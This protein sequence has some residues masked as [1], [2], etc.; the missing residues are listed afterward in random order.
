MSSRNKTKR[1]DGWNE[2]PY[3]DIYRVTYTTDGNFGKVEEQT[4]LNT[5]WHD[6]PVTISAD[7]KTL[8][9]SRDSHAEKK[10]E[11]DKKLN[12]K[13][14][15]VNLFRATKNGEKWENITALPFNSNTYSTS[16]PALSADGKT[17]YFSSDMPGSIGGTDIWKVSINGD[18]YGKPENLG[19]HVNTEGNEQFPFIT[20]D[21]LLYFASNGRTGLGGLDIFVANLAKNEPASNL[22]KPVNSEKDDF[23]FSFNASKNVGFISSNRTGNDDIYLIEPLCAVEAQI[24]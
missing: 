21:N 4:D 7:G 3:L 19:P 11:K 24:A 1:T 6:G 18:S 13:F 22:G 5:K 2:E 17:L 20:A 23:A 9:F 8:Y 10:F 14:G 15:Q 16:A 12:A